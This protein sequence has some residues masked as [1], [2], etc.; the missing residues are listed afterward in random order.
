MGIL[1]P[2]AGIPILDTSPS[3]P[4]G[5]VTWQDLVQL[6]WDIPIQWHSEGM[7]LM[8][9]RTWALI[10]T[11]SDA[12]APP[13]NIELPLPQCSGENVKCAA[14]RSCQA[15]FFEDTRLSGCHQVDSPVP[16]TRAGGDCRDCRNR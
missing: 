2:N 4:A 12:I 11:M 15:R 10:A 6:K 9:Q 3:T 16:T 8:N 14:T 1:N 7:Y 5:Q 13:E